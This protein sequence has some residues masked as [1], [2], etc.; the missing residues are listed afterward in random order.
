M[1]KQNER[2]IQVIVMAVGDAAVRQQLKDSLPEGSAFTTAI[3]QILAG[4]RDE[5][6]LCDELSYQQ[7]LIVIEILSRL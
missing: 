2:L 1:L 7:S 3:Q 6:T 5:E 4:V